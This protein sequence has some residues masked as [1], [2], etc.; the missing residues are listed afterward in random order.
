[1]GQCILFVIICC[2][3]TP[4]WLRFLCSTVSGA[5]RL[6]AQGLCTCEAFFVCVAL[7]HVGD[8]FNSTTVI[9]HFIHYVAVKEQ[10]R[11]VLHGWMDR[12]AGTVI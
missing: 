7:F 1:M 12:Q 6:V 4:H 5:G 2:I 10:K 3:K 11:A 9:M 8:Q